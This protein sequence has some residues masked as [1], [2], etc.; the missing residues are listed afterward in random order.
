M[1]LQLY[2]GVLIGVA[3]TGTPTRALFDSAQDADLSRWVIVGSWAVFTV[4]LVLV[5]EVPWRV[6]GRVTGLVCLT[7]GMQA[8]VRPAWRRSSRPPEG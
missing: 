3:V 2:G 7:L 4:S 6:A 8:A 5:F 1:L